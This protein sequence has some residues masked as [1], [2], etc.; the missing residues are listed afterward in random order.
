MFATF[1]LPT[2]R[3]FPCRNWQSGPLLALLWVLPAPSWAQN[4]LPAGPR[5]TATNDWQYSSIAGHEKDKTTLW[6]THAG[7]TASWQPAF[8]GP[9]KA[10]VFLYKIVQPQSNDPRVQL[11]IIHNGNTETQYVNFGAGAGGWQELGTFAFAGT[12]GEG[13]R[14]TKTSKEG[15][16]RA[17][18]VRFDVLGENDQVVQV[19]TIDDMVVPNSP[20][21]PGALKLKTNYPGGPPPHGAWEMTFHDDFEGDKL[22]TE[23]WKSQAGPSGHILSGRWPENV[24]VKDGLLRLL[25]KKEDRAGQNWTTGNIWTKSFKQQYGYFEA[26]MKIAKASGL[27]NAFWLM[28]DKK[29]TDPHH[30]EIDITEA[31]YPNRS[32]MTLH[33]WSGAHWAKSK[34]VVTQDDLSADFHIYAVEWTEKEI[35]FYLDGIEVH[36]LEHDICRDAA[37]LRLSSAVARFAGRVG[38]EL[39]GTSMD[40]D[41]VRVYRRKDAAH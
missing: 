32:N 12:A 23:V 2:H 14:L 9:V 15:A 4:K 7:A 19:V 1:P 22:N 10:R 39:D 37:P 31:H 28:T 13:V 26:R 25:T 16:T 20:P 21:V 35:V 24:Q 34:S 29:S 36:H 18:A 41:W 17:A 33:N 8:A 5:F 6:T 3:S 40:V 30:F 11:E 38:P 27:N